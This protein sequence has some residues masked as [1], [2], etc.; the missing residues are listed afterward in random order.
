[1]TRSFRGKEIDM[2]KLFHKNETKVAIG[3]GARVNARGDIL[4]RGGIIVKT[5]EE[6]IREY[7]EKVKEQEG[8]IGMKNPTELSDLEKKLREF[9]KPEKVTS[10]KKKEKVK[11]EK[12]EQPKKTEEKK[13]EIIFDEE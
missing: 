1:M 2:L 11:E 7:Q 12:T 5:R 3:N 9:Q 6:Q 10:K 4:G 8:E 13:E